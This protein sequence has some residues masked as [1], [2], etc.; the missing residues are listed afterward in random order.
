MRFEPATRYDLQLSIIIPV[1][2]EDQN[3]AALAEEISNVLYTLSTF[4]ECIWIDDGSTD[5]TLDELAKINRKDTCHQFISLARNYGQSAA[6]AVGFTSARGQILV[7][8]DGDGQNDPKNIP[9]M[10]NHL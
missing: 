10:I 4:W 7:T 8:M 2:D 5:T 6:L 3:V 1:K 9:A